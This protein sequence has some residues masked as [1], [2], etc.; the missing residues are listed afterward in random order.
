MDMQSMDQDGIIVPNSMLIFPNEQKTLIYQQ[1]NGV[2]SL[3]EISDESDGV[4]SL[5]EVPA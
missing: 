2:V 3:L 5:Q 4:V 1:T